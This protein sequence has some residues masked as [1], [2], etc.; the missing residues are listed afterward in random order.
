MLPSFCSQ[1][2]YT[3]NDHLQNFSVLA[4]GHFPRGSAYCD[5]FQ[6]VYLNRYYFH[7]FCSK[8]KTDSKHKPRDFIRHT[9]FI[10][11]HTRPLAVASTLQMLVFSVVL[12][13]RG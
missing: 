13:C 8:L 1:N 9:V 10:K 4:R 11:S 6:K 12:I 2:V 7:T 5:V 3:Y